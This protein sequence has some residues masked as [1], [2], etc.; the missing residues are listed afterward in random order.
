MVNRITIG[1]ESFSLNVLIAKYEKYLPIMKPL[2]RENIFE[3]KSNEDHEAYLK[4]LFTTL[5]NRSV[6]H[7]PVTRNRTSVKLDDGC[8]SILSA[9]GI[10]IVKKCPKR[11]SVVFKNTGNSYRMNNEEINKLT[12]AVKRSTKYDTRKKIANKNFKFGVELEFI[13]KRSQYCAFKDAIVARVGESRFYDAGGY[14]KNNGQ[15]WELGSDCSVKP[16][17][18]QCGCGMRGYELTSPIL[19]LSSKKDLKELADVCELI[20]SVFCGEVNSTCGTHI[21]VSFPVEKASRDL[22]M[23]FARSYRKSESSLFDKLVPPGRRENK[24]RY[25]KTVNVRYIGDRYRKLNFRN[26][27]ENSN[28]MH[29]EFRQ[30]DG[31]IDYEK[32]F[33]WIKLQKI[34]IDITLTSWALQCSDENKPVTIEL[35]D[36][37]TIKSLGSDIT[38]NLMKMSKMIA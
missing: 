27:E 16:R 6:V 8:D 29:L 30:L 14:H 1:D 15:K 20:K 36:V 25:A 31:T 10:G 13:G 37:I 3:Q 7:D 18:A 23:H 35:D 32:I 4:R 22:I 33:S 12:E 24:A 34:F 9:L 11:T 19:N 21:H 28:S 26:V 2:F 17:G 38:E 5:F